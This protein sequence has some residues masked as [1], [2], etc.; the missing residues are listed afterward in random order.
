[1]A[2]GEA[3]SGSQEADNAGNEQAAQEAVVLSIDA[4]GGDLGPTAV[5][6]G[7]AEALKQ[8]AAAD[9]RFLLHG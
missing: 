9:L 4:M 6:D 2:R 8:P 1:M 7:L 3:A 5:V